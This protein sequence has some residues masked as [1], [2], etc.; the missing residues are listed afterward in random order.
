MELLDEILH[1]QEI[2][3]D[4]PRLYESTLVLGDEVAENRGQSVG[5]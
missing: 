3:V 2:V 4:A 1:I 5:Q